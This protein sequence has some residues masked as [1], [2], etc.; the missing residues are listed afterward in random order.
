MAGE[1]TMPQLGLTMTEGTVSQWLKQEGDAVK[2]GDGVV[3]VETDKINNIV[4]APEDGILLKIVAREG[5][6]L[7]VKGLLGIIGAAGET[8]NVRRTADDTFDLPAIAAANEEVAAVSEL[9]GAI[10]VQNVVVDGRVLATP[11]ARFLAKKDGI[12]L[13]LVTGSGPNGRIVGD[14]VSAYKEEHKVRISPA[15]AKLAAELGVDTGCVQSDGR[16]MK[17]DVLRAAGAAAEV[18]LRQPDAKLDVSA[19]TAAKD[20]NKT[21]LKGMRKVIARRLSEGWR[22]T[23]HVHHTV[24]IDMT[25][26]TALRAAFK[27]MDKKL[28]F[29]DLIIKAL[30]R[31]LEEYTAANDSFADDYIIHNADINMGVA[32]AIDG[33]LIVP[34]I[35]NTDRLGV[36]QIHDKVGELAEKA[37]AGR[38]SPDEMQ[39]GTCTISNL[40]MYGCDHFTPIVNPPEAVILGVCRTVEKPIVKDGEIVIAPMMNA[41]L[42]YDHRVIDGATAGLVTSRLREYME[43]PLLLL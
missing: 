36:M 3:E 41:V 13:A 32:V 6:V 34:V 1:L 40:G 12:N 33:G 37:R 10:P 23:P 27:K 43:N 17:K 15:A 14:D 16:I 25:E 4:E 8:V 19:A 30:S 2:K 21:E 42:G 20:T 29:T 18:P 31:V 5:D 28:S 22:N 39:G 26:A 38:L 7:P 24:E 11:Y 9:S 35:K